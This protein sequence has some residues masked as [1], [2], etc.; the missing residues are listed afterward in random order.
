MEKRVDIT[1]QHVLLAARDLVA[2]ADSPEERAHAERR[3]MLTRGKR[4]RALHDG[5]P[6]KSKSSRAGT[7]TG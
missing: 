3:R 6:C 5:Q 2:V 4:S 7:A 1:M